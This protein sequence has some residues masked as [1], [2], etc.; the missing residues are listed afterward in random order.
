MDELTKQKGWYDR[1]KSITKKHGRKAYFDSV[2]DA[3]S[4]GQHLKMSGGP[5]RAAVSRK[6][7]YGKLMEADLDF[8]TLKRG[9]NRQRLEQANLK[10]ARSRH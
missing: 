3:A 5:R 4:L 10:A 1:F 6:H 8:A 7:G 2:R 9:K